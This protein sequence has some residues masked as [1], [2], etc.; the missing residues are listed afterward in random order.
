MYSAR[1]AVRTAREAMDAVDF[2]ASFLK[3]YDDHLWD[4]IGD[5]LQVS[6][7]LQKLGKVRPLLNFVIHKASR[8]DNVSN[9]I[10]GMIANEVPRKQLS[11]PLFYAKLLLS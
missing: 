10:G 9:I 11:N 5:E 8:S 7:R 6:H 4:A 1:Y 3:R 2:S